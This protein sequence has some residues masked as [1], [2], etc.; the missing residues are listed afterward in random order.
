M[1][2]RD[3]G[4]TLSRLYKQDA[5][6]G[7][8][9][10]SSTNDPATPQFANANSNYNYLPDGNDLTNWS[11]NAAG[12]AS[13]STKELVSNIAVP[14]P[15]GTKDVTHVVF[16][17]PDVTGNSAGVTKSFSSA[18]NVP[19]G[20]TV[21]RVMLMTAWFYNTLP[22]TVTRLTL[23]ITKRPPTD[24]TAVSSVLLPP[25]MWVKGS[26]LCVCGSDAG[27][28]LDITFAENQY[29]AEANA[30]LDFYVCD[31][32][33]RDVTFEELAIDSVTVG[34]PTIIGFATPHNI[35]DD[36]PLIINGLTGLTP[37]LS[38]DYGENDVTIALATRIDHNTISIPV[39]TSGTPA[40]LGTVGY[41]VID[42]YATTPDE[43]A[44]EQSDS[45][46]LGKGYPVM[47]IGDSIISSAQSG[48]SN[49]SVFAFLQAMGW[50]PNQQGTNVIDAAHPGSN[51]VVGAQ[52]SIISLVQA[53]TEYER[54]RCFAMISLGQD[55]TVNN[56]A[57]FDLVEEIVLEFTSRGNNNYLVG[58]FHSSR[59]YTQV[60]L[61]DVTAANAHLSSV[62]G[63]RFVDTYQALLDES[64][65][66][67]RAAG[68][69][70]LPLLGDGD[71]IHP[72][73]LGMKYFTK[74]YVDKATALGYGDNTGRIIN[75]PITHTIR[76]ND[77]ET[78]SIEHF[79]AAG[80]TVVTRLSMATAQAD[81][82]QSNGIVSIDGNAASLVY[83]DVGGIKSVQG[84][85]EIDVGFT[86]NEMLTIAIRGSSSGNVHLG[87]MQAGI[88][89]W[90]T[91][92]AY[93]APTLDSE[94]NY[95]V[96]AEGS[97]NFEINEYYNEEKTQAWIEANY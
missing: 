70:S 23:G 53:T 77:T 28:N 7:D 9:G 19:Q 17:D 71:S 78:D 12:T 14:S 79:N 74:A 6:I 24:S 54:K 80:F 73:Q 46:W 57:I 51:L 1:T 65:A 96:D 21:R 13:S 87:V 5:S 33:L 84:T 11:F 22:D 81:M 25:Q 37:D 32:S 4:A 26:C 40:G 91:P 10:F 85:Q 41:P 39:S 72:S 66:E 94:I 18:L 61:D 15:N 36:T 42:T 76:T 97:C 3:K 34:N 83:A 56:Q 55:S 35:Q 49:F 92:G 82:I 88:W 75:A 50:R 86:A 95:C 30:D 59:A 45:I 90:D 38:T 64:S 60:Q 89:T 52:P 43:L 27:K 31:A 67:D 20:D 62:Y 68:I 47:S 16:K 2:I 8:A 48:T 29:S 69:I 93:V 44:G 58:G 63:N